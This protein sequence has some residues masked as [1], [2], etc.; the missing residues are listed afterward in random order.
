M[1][2]LHTEINKGCLVPE[3]LTA[4]V[5]GRRSPGHG[6]TPAVDAMSAE[7]A[8]ITVD[9]ETPAAVPG[10]A[11]AD[12]TDAEAPPPKHYKTM[13]PKVQEWFLCT[14]HIMA[15][16]YGWGGCTHTP[17]GEAT[18]SGDIWPSAPRHT[19]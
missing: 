6:L 8:S 7:F 14:H 9:A 1:D 15:T 10:S 5:P 16:K 19:A 2:L 13:D 18:G 17:V 11:S 12:H 3:G 4:S